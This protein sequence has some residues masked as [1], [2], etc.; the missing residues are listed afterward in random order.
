MVNAPEL[1]S[2]RKRLGLEDELDATR[3]VQQNIGFVQP[4]GVNG[5]RDDVIPPH[6]PPVSQNGRVQHPTHM[7]YE[8]D[9]ADFFV[10]GAS[11]ALVLPALPPGVK[12]TITSTMIQLIN[13]KEM[14]RWTIVI[15]RM[16]I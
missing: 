14:F 16:D 7:M 10:V 5:N 1:E 9:D 15:M 8:K 3:H 6:C 2:K 4:R 11:G 12:L 13:L